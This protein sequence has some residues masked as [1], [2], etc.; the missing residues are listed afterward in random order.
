MSAKIA[1]FKVGDKV[2]FRHY[3]SFVPMIIDK[4]FPPSDKLVC[5]ENHMYKEANNERLWYEDQL[6]LLEGDEDENR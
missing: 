6:I 2:G 4:V 1:K 5:G 3:P